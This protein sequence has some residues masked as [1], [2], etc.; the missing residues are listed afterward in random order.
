MRICLIG[1]YFPIQGGVSTRNY[2]MAHELAKRGHQVHVVTNAREVE[3]PWRLLMRPEDWERCEADYGQGSVRVSWTEAMDRSQSFIPRNNP[4]VTKLVSLALAAHKEAPF[5]IVHSYYLEP[6]GVAGH[7]VSQA[8]DLPH[9]VKT[10]GSDAGKLWNHPQFE[11]FYDHVLSSA[12]LFVAGGLVTQRA[13]DHGVDPERVT[14][15]RGF[16]LATDVFCPDGKTLDLS[17]ILALAEASDDAAFADL[18]WGSFRG[19][20][21]YI[22]VYG[23]LGKGKGSFALLD[24][25]ARARSEGADIGLVA[26]AHG[27]P[28]I[29]AQFRQ[30]VEAMELKDHVLQIP[31]LPHWRVPDFIRSCLAVCC[32]EQDFTI[33]IHNP[34]V[35]EEVMSCGACLVASTELLNKHSHPRQLVSGVNCLAI[36]NVNDVEELSGT[37]ASVT[38]EPEKTLAMGARARRYVERFDTGMAFAARTEAIFDRTLRTRP[39]APFAVVDPPKTPGNISL[40][41]MA[42]SMLEPGHREACLASAKSEPESPQWV[43][44]IRR[45]TRDGGLKGAAAADTIETAIEVDCAIRTVSTAVSATNEGNSGGQEWLFRAGGKGVLSEGDLLDLHPLR[46]PAVRLLNFDVSI[47]PFISARAATD[48]PDKTVAGKSYLAVMP[49]AEDRHTVVQLDHE[50]AEILQQSDGNLSARKIACDLG[51]S[52]VADLDRVAARLMAL[53]IE[54]VLVF[55]PA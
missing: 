5:D 55:R 2:H 53:L 35:T 47:A 51:L 42:L 16:Q 21:P 54:G 1:K 41:Q 9:V 14:A 48:L 50:M 19:D 10:A 18:C 39:E 8:L 7:L 22:G 46:H 43:D 34:I 27:H 37:L 17:E 13:I 20:R 26:M 28:P 4:S 45:W 29:E 30:T 38:R 15:N 11:P 52:E 36:R 40:T 31:F 33:T 32:L 6:Y 49:L 24:A 44:E 25:L 23:K 12:D 3:L